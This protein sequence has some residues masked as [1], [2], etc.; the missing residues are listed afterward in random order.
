MIRRGV[1]RHHQKNTIPENRLL[2]GA[3][4]VF[5][6]KKNGTYRARCVVLG[7]PQIPGVVY[8]V[9]FSPVVNDVTL[10][11][12][13]IITLQKRWSRLTLDFQ[14]AFLESDLEEDIFMKLSPGYE[15]V[16]AD[17]G[18]DFKDILDVLDNKTICELKKTIFGLVQAALMWYKKISDI[19]V[20]KL[21]FKKNRKDP[22]LF[23]KNDKNGEVIICLYVMYLFLWGYK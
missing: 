15:K 11:A 10:R 9:N 7:F 8:T 5:K 21:S 17:L 19:L 1:W 20:K 23:Y 13:L 2:I 12:A 22:C 3:K 16:L 6:V 18:A 4:W 14:M